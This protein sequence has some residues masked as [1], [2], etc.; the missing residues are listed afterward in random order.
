VIPRPRTSPLL[1]L[2]CLGLLVPLGVAL[3]GCWEVL[4]HQEDEETDDQ[5]LQRDGTLEVSPASLDLA[6]PMGASTSSTL[7]FREVSGTAGVEMELALEGEG[8]EFVTYRPGKWSLIVVPA[9]SLDVQVT[10]SP[11]AGAT[12]ADLELVGTTTGSPAEIRVPIH[13]SLNGS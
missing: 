11:T 10:F 1:S 13:L 5:W 3:G 12:E 2:L 9:G 6:T 7:T 4:S 8:A